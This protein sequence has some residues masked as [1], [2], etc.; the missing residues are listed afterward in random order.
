VVQGVAKM[1]AGGLHHS[2]VAVVVIAC[3]AAAAV[4]GG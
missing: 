2:C 4:Q 1:R 3:V